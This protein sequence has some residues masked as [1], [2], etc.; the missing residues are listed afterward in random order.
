MSQ[1]VMPS[2]GADM[3]AGT[4]VEWLKQPGEKVARGDIIAVVETQKGAIEV[5]VFENGLL[6]EYLIDLG[7]RVPVGTPM[8][9]ILQASEA[10]QPPPTEAPSK[11]A[12][13]TAKPGPTP[14]PAAKPKPSPVTATAA[15]KPPAKITQPNP[16]NAAR[17]RITPAARRQAARQA[18]DLTTITPGPDG[19]IALADIPA[20]SSPLQPDHA[21]PMSDMRTAIAAAMSRSKREIPHYYL[22]DTIDIS[23]AEKF[24]T[25]YN[26]KR[27]PDQRL[28]LG[29]LYLKSVAKALAK[30]P[31]FNGHFITD[32]FHASSAAHI[33][34]ATSI[35][36]G[37]LI[38]PALHDVQALTL[39]ELMEAMRD[40]VSRARAGRFRARELSGATI[41]VTSLGDRGVDLLYGV[42][43]PPQVAIIGFGTASD[44]PW[45]H[46]G[47]IKPLRTVTLTL[48]A[49]HRVSDGHRGALFLNTIGNFL[50]T[51]ET[52]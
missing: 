7:A 27:P 50:Q 8:A 14:R 42:I 26:K 43:N 38:A 29:V 9:T 39:D 18:V 51:P 6:G 45:I 49:D 2:L 40:L 17:Q 16:Q 11:P 5:E 15:A 36:S 35:R 1:F 22:A 20:P 4:L 21:A 37:G 52:I 34:V 10:Q 44:R 31:E 13:P 46:K 41:T 30:Y 47:K 19:V 12:K 28:L 23:A 33:G 24:V 48:A 3:E 25:R 32:Q